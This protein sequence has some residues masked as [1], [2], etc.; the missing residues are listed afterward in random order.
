VQLNEYQKQAKTFA[1]FVNPKHIEWGLKAEAGE[2]QGKFA[3]FYR[4]D[5]IDLD[6]ELIYECGDVLWYLALMV[7]ILGLNLEDFYEKREANINRER[8]ADL[9]YRNCS[10]ISQQFVQKDLDP[11]YIKITLRYLELAAERDIKEIAE[12]NIV[13][14]A[15]RKARKMIKGNGDHR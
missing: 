7:D 14:L 5:D 11:L 2:V 8:A 12:I 4:G 10:L 13:K 1:A 9:V 15:D 3:K 6:A